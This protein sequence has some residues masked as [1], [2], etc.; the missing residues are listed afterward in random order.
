MGSDGG[1]RRPLR[2]AQVGCGQIS[3]A[4][5]KA[6]ADTHLVE[7]AIVV[8]IDPVAAQEA[9]AANGGVP[10][11]TNVEEALRRDDVDVVSVATPHYLHA[12]HAVAALRAGKHVLCEKPLTVTLEDADSMIFA[13]QDFGR[14]LGM[15]MVM[16]YGPA[17]RAAR[18]LIRDGAIGRIVNV[19][20]PDVHNKAP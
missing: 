10:W 14:S 17:A 8:D 20:L 2:V 15:W 19:R 16:R 13:A 6:Y 9:A 4:H 11:T 12:P 18:D 7:V 5:F 1:G 3:A